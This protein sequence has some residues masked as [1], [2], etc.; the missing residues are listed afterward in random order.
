MW[1]Y[2]T[3]GTPCSAAIYH[4]LLVLLSCRIYKLAPNW[5]NVQFSFPI[6]F[7]L[8]Q[9]ILRSLSKR[10]STTRCYLADLVLLRRS[11]EMRAHTHHPQQAGRQKA[12]EVE[13]YREV[14]AWESSN[15]CDIEH[16]GAKGWRAREHPAKK[17]QQRALQSLGILLSCRC[18]F[19]R[20]GWGLRLCVSNKL[21]GVADAAGS[22]AMLWVAIL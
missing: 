17:V 21:P 18:W 11:G 5:C 20:S 12:W 3:A 6:Y 16:P 14:L 13:D 19:N 1:L 4:F 22:W 7:W 9:A 10:L 8:S 2:I 15:D